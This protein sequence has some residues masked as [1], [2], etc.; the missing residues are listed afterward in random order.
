MALH[1]LKSWPEPFAKIRAGKKTYEIRVDDRGYREGD[2]ICLYKWVPETGK[3]ADKDRDADGY[4]GEM[5]T[6]TIIDVTTAGSLIGPLAGCLRAD[7]V[8]LGVAWDL[9][10][11][12]INR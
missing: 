10:A 3:E 7:S 1:I 6:G 5:V 11:N 2:K 8:I 12:P 9:P 4:T